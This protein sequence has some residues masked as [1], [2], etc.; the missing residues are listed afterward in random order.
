MGENKIKATKLQPDEKRFCLPR[1]YSALHCWGQ[2]PRAPPWLC[3]GWGGPEAAPASCSCLGF[4]PD[5]RLKEA[6]SKAKTQMENP[7]PGP[8]KVA[9]SLGRTGLRDRGRA[10]SGVE[11][12]RQSEGTQP[13]HFPEVL[14]AA[15]HRAQGPPAQHTLSPQG[16]LLPEAEPGREQ[17]TSVTGCGETWPRA[18]PVGLGDA[19]G[20]WEGSSERG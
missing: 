13:C 12:S 19:C 7:G 1:L 18:W 6:A 9:M 15:R 14:S 2:S 5:L 17:D 4:N 8:T 16:R 20:Q 10:G 3:R 11:G